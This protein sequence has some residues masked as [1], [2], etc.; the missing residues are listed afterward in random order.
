MQLITQPTPWT[1]QPAAFAMCMGVPLDTVL[2]MLGHD[3]GRIDNFNATSTVWTVACFAPAELALAA[4]K[5][6]Y[7]V[8]EVPAAIVSHNG[9]PVKWYPKSPGALMSIFAPGTRFVL[10]VQ[11]ETT[12]SSYHC[13]AHE[14]GTDCYHDPLH[15]RPLPL[16][17]LRPIKMIAAVLDLGAPDGPMPDNHSLTRRHTPIVD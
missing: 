8:V 5:L 11:S 10:T 15:P 4:Y 7:A 14:L 16:N 9:Q 2:A 12:P 3:G 13:V 6:G 1:C 17:H